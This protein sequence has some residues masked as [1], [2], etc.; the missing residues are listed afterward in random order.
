MMSVKKVTRVAAGILVRPD[1]QFLLSSRPAGKVYAGYWEFPGGKL[2]ENESALAAL[3]RELHEELGIRVT[4][5]RPWIC[6]RFEYPHATVELRFFIV[7][8]WEGELHSREAQQFAWLRV[9]QLTQSPILPANGPILRGLALPQRLL[10]SPGATLPAAQWLTKMAQYWQAEPAWLVLREPQCS[11]EE[12]RALVTQL[13]QMPRPHGGKLLV[14][15]PHSASYAGEADGWHLTSLQLS[16]LDQRPRGFNWVG[17][18][19]H[20]ESQL[21]A[22]NQLGLDYTL[23]GHVASTASHPQ[24]P[25]LGWEE[26]TRLL[27]LGWAAP[28]YAIGGQSVS[29]LPQAHAAGAHGVAVLR[30]AW[31]SE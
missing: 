10:I 31:I 16:A 12:Y 8:A 17:A 29:T 6:Q 4:A 15:G 28:C 13:Q 2:E 30:D 3:Q 20:N 19:C 22:A 9:G 24:Q 27:A 23:L 25:P 1:G 14:H 21:V 26:F 18:S 11:K 5:A 7:T